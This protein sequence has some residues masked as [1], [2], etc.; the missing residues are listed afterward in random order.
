MVQKHKHK[1]KHESHA[2]LYPKVTN[3]K[4]IMY[5]FWKLLFKNHL[6]LP[7]HTHVHT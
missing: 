1:M 7:V 4:F 5:S 3:F 2:P 6:Y